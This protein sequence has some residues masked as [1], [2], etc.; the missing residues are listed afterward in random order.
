MLGGT[1]RRGASGALRATTTAAPATSDRRSTLVPARLSI[2]VCMGST[3]ATW[4]ATSASSS[5]LKRITTSA[6]PLRRLT[7]VR[8]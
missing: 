2:T 3:R 6:S 5:L 7:T 1:S 8:A 4:M